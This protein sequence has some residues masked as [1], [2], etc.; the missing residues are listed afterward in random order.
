MG[1]KADAWVYPRPCGETKRFCL[2]VH[3]IL[4]LSPPVRGNRM[5]EIGTRSFEGSIPARAGKPSSHG[6]V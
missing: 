3:R 4:G 1:H 2:V 5:L 6:M